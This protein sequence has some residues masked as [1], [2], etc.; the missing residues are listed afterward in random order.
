MHSP[1]EPL[2]INKHVIFTTDCRAGKR[3][4]SFGAGYRLIKD[5]RSIPHITINK[6]VFFPCDPSLWGIK[7]T[8]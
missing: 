3:E 1:K 8:Q 4:H 6:N 2:N 7:C 5:Q